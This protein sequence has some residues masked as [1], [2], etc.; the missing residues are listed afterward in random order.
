MD[1]STPAAGDYIVHVSQEGS[2]PPYSVSM[3]DGLLRFVAGTSDG[4]FALGRH[5]ARKNRV[6]LWT[7]DDGDFVCLARFRVT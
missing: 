4:A 5:H 3:R 1:S 2:T 6:D 7:D